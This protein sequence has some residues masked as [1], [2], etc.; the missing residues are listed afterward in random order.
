MSCSPPH[1]RRACSFPPH[2]G[3]RAMAAKPI[4]EGYHTATIYLIVRGAAKAIEFYKQAFGATEMLRLASPDGKVGHAEIKIGDSIIM[5][6][7]EFPEWGHKS[8][9]ALGGAGSG[10]CLCGEGV[11]A[12]LARAV[13]AGGTEKRPVKD[14]FY[15]VRSGTIEDPFGH[16]WT[17]ATHKEDVSAEEITRRF[18]A[19]MKQA[20]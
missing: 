5:L 12:R 19:S 4:P 15:G 20:G 14:Q 9:Q 1:L 16:V 10:I 2:D 8:P 11:D 13:A 17:I 6:A 18:A 7:D 3:G